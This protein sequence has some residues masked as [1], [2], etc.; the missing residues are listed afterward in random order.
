MTSRSRIALR[1]MVPLRDIAG[2]VELS[3]VS[4]VAGR[5]VGLLDGILC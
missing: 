1:L 4:N 2:P 3:M 5:K